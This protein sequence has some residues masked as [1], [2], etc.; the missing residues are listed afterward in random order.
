MAEIIPYS[1]DAL[2]HLI[3]RVSERLYQG[4]IVAIPTET[5]YGLAVDPFDEAAVERLR[6]LKGREDGKPILVLI[7]SMD[8]LPL[9]ARE[10]PSI[11]KILIEAFWPGP[12]TILFPAV[13]ALPVN[14]TA[15]TGL[16]GIRLSSSKPLMALLAHV[17]PLTGTSANLAAQPPARTAMMV[18]QALGQEV[19]LIVDAGTTAGGLPST[20]IDVQQPLRV[21]R[22]GAV[23]RQMIQN[24][25]QTHGISLV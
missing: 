23:T 9:L 3:R 25:L 14:L 11:A 5:F 20:V 19:D 13:P 12:L 16:V 24:V 10:V 22:D 15:G 21:V 6:R 17:G 18:E 1:P 4:G 2:P 8:Q 7:G